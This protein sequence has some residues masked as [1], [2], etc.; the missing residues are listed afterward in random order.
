MVLRLYMAGCL[1]AALW[2]LEFSLLIK[3]ISH[4]FSV[5]QRLTK[6][7]EQNK[8]VRASTFDSMETIRIRIINFS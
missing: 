8:H 3:G 5:F 6:K 4:V 7:K 1:A 2:R